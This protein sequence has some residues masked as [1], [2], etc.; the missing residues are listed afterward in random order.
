MPSNTH[1]IKQLKFLD[2][3]KDPNSDALMMINLPAKIHSMVL[4]AIEDF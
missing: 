3:S 2:S 1:A 4:A